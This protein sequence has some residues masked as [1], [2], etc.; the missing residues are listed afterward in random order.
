MRQPPG[1]WA[2]KLRATI[3]HSYKIRW[4]PLEIGTQW[5]LGLARLKRRPKTEAG[6]HPVLH[7]RRESKA[8][9]TP[10]TSALRS[11]FFKQRQVFE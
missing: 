6:T 10:C 1:D 3:E 9:I 11:N 5:H 7:I 2:L 8:E 4:V